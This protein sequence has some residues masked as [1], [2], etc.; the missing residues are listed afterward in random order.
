MHPSRLRDLRTFLKDDS[1]TFKDPQQSLA[2]EL[3][4]GKEPSLLV[5]GPTGEEC[6]LRFVRFISSCPTQ[7]S[8]KTLPIFMSTALYDGGATTVLILA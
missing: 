4:R 1:A 8:G 7:G 5:I 2:L 3:I 6:L